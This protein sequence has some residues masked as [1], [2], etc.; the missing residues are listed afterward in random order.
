[1]AR[2]IAIS[3]QKGG[4]G[5]TTTAINLA[6][7]L[8]EA[9][10]NVLVVDLD[11][12]GNTTSGLGLDKD[13]GQT[14]YHVLMGMSPPPEAVRRTKEDRLDVV[15]A[16]RDL[17]G[18]EVELLAQNGRE[19]RLQTALKPLREKYDYV[20]I[21]CPP[22]LNILTLNALTAADSVL[23]PLQCEYF[24]M[25]GLGELVR[26]LQL[27]KSRLN[28]ALEREG[29]LLTMFDKRNRLAN[30]VNDEVRRLFGALVFDT[31]IP[32]NIRLGESPSF[33]EPITR[34]D[35]R[36]SGATAYRAL[37]DELLS[38]ARQRTPA[39]GRIQ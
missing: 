35:A 16:N 1:M 19:Y 15:G 27:V 36:S 18:A 11:P 6:A 32:R 3:N 2:V 37:A 8:A 38:R 23:I 25:E 14:I 31:V 29:I 30:Q 22:S 39:G 26:T 10:Q 12:Q 17:V 4:V 33:G 7:S 28:P 21:D 5:K 24:A 34:Y 9:G 20:V 13:A